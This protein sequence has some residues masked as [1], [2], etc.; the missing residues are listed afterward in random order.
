[1]MTIEI[2][3]ESKDSRFSVQCKLPKEIT[4]RSELFGHTTMV[5]AIQMVM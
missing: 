4:H 2:L 1:M 5:A 3:G